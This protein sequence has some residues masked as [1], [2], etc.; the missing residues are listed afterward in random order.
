MNCPWC[1]WTSPPRALHAHLADVHP[2]GVQFEEADRSRSYV[3]VC[4]LCG[5]SHVQPIK[6]RSRDPDFLAE[7]EREI[8][9]VGFDMLVNH[10][11][12]EHDDAP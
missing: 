3:V 12:A 2:E 5:A 4:P 11:L 8:R 7:Y 1:T 6:P 10:L 9:L